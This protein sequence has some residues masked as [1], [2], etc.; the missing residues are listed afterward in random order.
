LQAGAGR[1]PLTTQQALQ[2]RGTP[3]TPQ[4]FL[5]AIASDARGC[6]KDVARTSDTTNMAL[7]RP[8]E[9][10]D[11]RTILVFGAFSIPPVL[12]SGS[13]TAPILLKR[14]ARGRMKRWALQPGA[15]SSSP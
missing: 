15:A 13:I 10:G 7:L 12:S 8:V 1:D 11:R 6:L 9:A 5:R 4:H 14:L 2:T 3:A